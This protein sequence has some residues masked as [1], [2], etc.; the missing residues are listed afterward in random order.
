MV[1]GLQRA[2][3]RLDRVQLEL[4]ARRSFHLELLVDL[5]QPLVLE[6]EPEVVDGEDD[7]LSGRLFGV[8]VDPPD[9]QR[10][11]ALEEDEEEQTDEV[12]YPTAQFQV[13]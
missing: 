8:D 12:G 11:G 5:L 4:S 2:A 10:V 13:L 3:A 6:D 1:A 7:A 9:Q